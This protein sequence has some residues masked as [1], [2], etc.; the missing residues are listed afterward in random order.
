MEVVRTDHSGMCAALKNQSMNWKYSSK[1]RQKSNAVSRILLC[2]SSKAVHYF[3]FM[4]ISNH[5]S[6][7]RLEC[8]MALNTT[9]RTL[10]VSVTENCYTEACTLEN[11]SLNHL[12]TQMS[13]CQNC[14]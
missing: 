7:L 14:H 3:T 4:F 9:I 2:L 6:S 13:L 8:G 12:I 10:G 5:V 11:Q 1:L